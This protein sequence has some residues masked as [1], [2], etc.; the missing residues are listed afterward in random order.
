MIVKSNLFI[1]SAFS[2][3]SIVGIEKQNYEYIEEIIQLLMDMKNGVQYR[4]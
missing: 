4:K 2:D 1:P 3:K